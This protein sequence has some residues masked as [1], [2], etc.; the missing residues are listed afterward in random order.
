MKLKVFSAAK[1]NTTW[2]QGFGNVAGTPAGELK[3]GDTMVWNNGTPTK[4]GKI[5]K[6]TEKTVV[7][8]D[9]YTDG[10]GQERIYERKLLKSRIVARP[11]HEL[12]E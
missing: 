7:L 8:E 3:T 9:V 11:A 6:Q 12:P 4:V 10:N 2:I 5:L 1:A